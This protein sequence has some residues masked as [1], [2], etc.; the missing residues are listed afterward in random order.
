VSGTRLRPSVVLLTLVVCACSATARG[1]ATVPAPARRP[2]VRTD[3]VSGHQDGLALTLD[4]HAHTCLTVDLDEMQRRAGPIDA[5][6]E[7]DDKLR[8]PG[9]ADDGPWRGGNATT[10]LGRSGRVG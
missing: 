10:S 6:H 2:S 4:V 5:G 7:A 8:D 1:I 3:L 9:G